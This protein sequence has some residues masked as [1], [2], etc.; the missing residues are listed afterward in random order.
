MAQ[1]VSTP[2]VK[3][4]ISDQSLSAEDGAD[5]Q[6]ETHRTR[7]DRVAVRLHDTARCRNHPFV[8]NE[9]PEMLE[10]GEWRW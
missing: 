10:V 2:Q 5:Q 4:E 8:E 7:S 9:F 3:P 6:N 1:E